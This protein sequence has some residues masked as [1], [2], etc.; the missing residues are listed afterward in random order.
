MNAPD[1]AVND[2]ITDLSQAKQNRRVKKVKITK[3]AHIGQRFDDFLK[4]QG[5]LEEVHAAAVK[6]VADAA[7][8]RRRS[9]S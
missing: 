6:R 2:T 1:H 9:T 8:K 7:R 3:K 5:T 4:Q